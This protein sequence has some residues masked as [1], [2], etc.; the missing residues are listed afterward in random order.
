MNLAWM[1]SAA[2]SAG[3][4]VLVGGT[5]VWY[6]CSGRAERRHK[7]LVV[8]AR[9]QYA[10]GTQGLRATNARLQASLE[11]EKQTVQARL[12]QAAREHR[13]ELSR[14][15]GQLR[16]A[17]AEIDRLQARGP[18]EAPPDVAD[19]RGFALTRPFER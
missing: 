16:Y 14:V 19:G 2:T 5:V 17:Y 10:T 15:E 6:V 18:D 4:G 12:D 3:L 7:R 8:A 9:E 1:I 13:A 11:T